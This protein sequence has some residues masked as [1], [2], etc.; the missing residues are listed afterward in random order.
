M[1]LPEPTRTG[2]ANLLRGSDLKTTTT[3]A[4]IEDF[5]TTDAL[6]NKFLE[7]NGKLQS[8]VITLKMR[9]GTKDLAL[10]ITNYRILREKLGDNSEKWIGKRIK[11]IKTKQRNPNTRQLVDAITVE[12]G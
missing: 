4:V 5:R 12:A 10:N 2:A 1:D 6:R 7:I 9:D 11:P 3:T 8:P